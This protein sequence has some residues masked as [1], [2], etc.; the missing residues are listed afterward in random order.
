MNCPVCGVDNREGA[1]FCR[2]CGAQVLEAEEG[3]D[4]KMEETVSGDTVPADTALADTAPDAFESPPKG[5]APEGEGQEAANAGSEA[6]DAP[7]EDGDTG[8]EQV[9]PEPTGAAGDAGV[10]PGTSRVTRKATSHWTRTMMT[11]WPSGATRW[12][13]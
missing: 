11:S 9:E 13:P 2:E 1:R 5:A 6:L 4:P 12:S 8:D 3:P 10:E 7:V